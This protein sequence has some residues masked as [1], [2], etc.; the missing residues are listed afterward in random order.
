LQLVKPKKIY[1]CLA[2]AELAGQENRNGKPIAVLFRNVSHECIEG[3][4]G[5]CLLLAMFIG[6]DW[7]VDLMII[8]IKKTIA[9][10]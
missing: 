8:Y 1:S 3:K 2:I 7:M 4:S 6:G 9:K 5:I 10:A